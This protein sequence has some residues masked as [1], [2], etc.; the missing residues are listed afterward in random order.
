[1]FKRARPRATR[2][3]LLFVPPSAR[4]LRS[5]SRTEKDKKARVAAIGGSS[6]CRQPNQPWTAPRPGDRRPL[7][8]PRAPQP[9]AMRPPCAPSPCAA[10]HR[11]PLRLAR[12]LLPLLLLLAAATGALAQGQSSDKQGIRRMTWTRA[13][14]SSRR[15]GGDS[16]GGPVATGDGVATVAAHQPAQPGSQ[17]ADADHRNGRLAVAVALCRAHGPV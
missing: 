17:R 4:R 2:L 7:F 14:R 12:A 6:A 13:A 3:A 1:M 15:W 5:N 9:T 8:Q 11:A 16:G 10:G